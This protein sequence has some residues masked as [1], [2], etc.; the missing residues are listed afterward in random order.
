MI[1]YPTNTAMPNK[2]WYPAMLDYIKENW[3]I[4]F[5]WQKYILI[6]KKLNEI[7]EKIQIDKK[8]KPMVLF[9]K[10]CNE[11]RTS[12][13]PKVTISSFIHTLIRFEYINKNDGNKLLYQWK[14]YRNQKNIDLYGDKIIL[15][16]S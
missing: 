13:F 2:T 12:K 1:K 14:K 6:C 11:Y 7:L 16:N 15:E 10:K 8:L 5:N 4:S 9:C 3:D